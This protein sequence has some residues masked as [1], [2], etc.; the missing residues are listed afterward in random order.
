MRLASNSA[1]KSDSGGGWPHPGYDA[2]H[3]FSEIN[4]LL[5]L[6]LTVE[7]D[8]EK[9]YYCSN[10]L[11][12]FLLETTLEFHPVKKLNYSTPGRIPGDILVNEAKFVTPIKLT[13]PADKAR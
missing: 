13:T 6:S 9:Y 11:I 2:S 12:P 4:L 8:H 7:E 5:P 10:F 1:G 3:L